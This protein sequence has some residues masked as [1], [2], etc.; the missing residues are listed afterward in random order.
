MGLGQVNVHTLADDLLLK[1]I[2]KIIMDMIFCANERRP[3]GT[4]NSGGHS[5]ANRFQNWI[6]HPLEVESIGICLTCRHK[7]P[8]QSVYF[9]TFLTRL[10]LTSIFDVELRQH[11][12]GFPVP[13][14]SWSAYCTQ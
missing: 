9:C 6:L 5:T 11:T 14:N 1:Y 12:K 10:L 13:R 7:T 2:S 4:I 3:V 8:S